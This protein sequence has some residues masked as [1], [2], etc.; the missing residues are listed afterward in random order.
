MVLFGGL[1]FLPGD[2]KAADIEAYL[3]NKF[4]VGS[5]YRFYTHSSMEMTLVRENRAAIE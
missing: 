4:S 5:L 3:V 1:I 2:Y